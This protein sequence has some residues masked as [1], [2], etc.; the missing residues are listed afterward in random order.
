M[1]HHAYYVFLQS[2]VDND[3]VKYLMSIFLLYLSAGLD[4]AKIDKCMGDPDADT[5]NSILKEEQDAQVTSFIIAFS[6]C[7]HLILCNIIF[8]CRFFYET[9]FV[10]WEGITR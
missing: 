9:G 3:F 7:Y 1:N 2:L 6:L 5:E 8:M 4:I 10:D